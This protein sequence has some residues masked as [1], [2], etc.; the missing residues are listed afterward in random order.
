MPEDERRRTA[1]LQHVPSIDALVV[2]RGPPQERLAD[3]HVGRR[4]GD[5]IRVA[6]RL[7]DLLHPI[8]EDRWRFVERH[9]TGDADPRR[10]RDEDRQRDDD[11]R[12][13]GESDS[14]AERFR[15]TGGDQHFRRRRLAGGQRRGQRIAAGQCRGNGE[16]RSGS[17]ERV[18]FEAAQDDALDRRIEIRTTSIDG[19]VMPPVSCSC[20][21][22]ASDFASSRDD[23]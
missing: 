8:G 2:R 3:R 22:S 19:V 9:E 17:L 5:R 4:V 7:Q 18:L 23:R 11:G 10:D 6:E 12:D 14:H 21:R 15:F 13:A 20:L 1:G 16:R